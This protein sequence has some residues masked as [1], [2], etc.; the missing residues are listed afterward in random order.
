MSRIFASRRL[1]RLA[2]TALAFAV[3]FV[4]ISATPHN[5]DAAA[6][7]HLRLLRSSPAADTVLTAAPADVRLWFSESPELKVTTVRLA[8]P[9][10][11]VE[12]GQLSRGEAA[13]APIVAPVKG[14]MASGAYTLTWRTMSDDGHVMNGTEKFQLTAASSR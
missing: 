5:A 13:D 3:T 7:R 12:L 11:A 9:S 10:G 14:A 2:L 4:A 6:R 8:G 1:T